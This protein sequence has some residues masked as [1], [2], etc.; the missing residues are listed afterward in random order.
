MSVSN[1][2]PHIQ[3]HENPFGFSH[4]DLYDAFH[5]QDTTDAHNA[6]D[7][8]DHMAR[9]WAADVATFAARIQRSS[10]SA[11]EGPAAEA[12]RE[13]I[14]TYAQRA[15]DLTPALMALAEQVTTAAIGIVNTKK[16][17][18]P[19]PQTTVGPWYKHAFNTDGWDFLYHGPRSVSKINE[20]KEK[21]QAAMQN[22]YLV[23]FV[24]AD[25][26]I[27]VL[28]EPVSPANPLYSWQPGQSGIDHGPAGPG[29]S[30]HTGPD[31][32]GPSGSG[33]HG[34]EHDTSDQPTGASGSSSDATSPD[35]RDDP[36]AGP[37]GLGPDDTRSAG[38]NPGD[39]LTRP[40]GVDP[41]GLPGGGYGGG[42]HGPGSESPG[43]TPGRS[44]PGKPMAPGTSVRPMAAR[45]GAPGVP[46]MGMPAMAPPGK[47]KSEEDDRTHNTPDWLKNKKN[48]EELL[49]T[50]PRTL[51][52]GVIGAEDPAPA[53]DNP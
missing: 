36:S 32:N 44:L 24:R 18:E 37:R 27:P 40:T 50:P 29:G 22:N 26:R 17:V 47:G 5:P 10:A 4:R 25:S 6:A 8:Y 51:P 1:E 20:A 39:S 45:A 19:E 34:D 30:G 15:Q 35:R 48:T 38:T 12:S 9:S 28:P 3:D 42:G 2:P 23:D 13:A 49:G 14:N 52:G 41:T 31:S 43:A 11:W 33:D 46:G 16:G 21:A 53:P 7:K